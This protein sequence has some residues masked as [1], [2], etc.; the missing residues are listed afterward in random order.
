MLSKGSVN[1]L[2]RTCLALMVVAAAAVSHVSWGNAA[3]ED[4]VSE[5]P[6]GPKT[7]GSAISA[8]DADPRGFHAAAI[9]IRPQHYGRRQLRTLL[10]N[11]RTAEDHALLAAYFRARER[12]FRTKEADQQKLLAE[13]LK[14]NTSKGP[15]RG[16]TIKDSA[17][18]YRD[19]ARKEADLALVHE[20]LAAELGAKK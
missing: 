5:S 9:L 13:Y 2:A 4:S 6:V 1:L 14:G 10:R 15:A 20:R 17:S 12:E 11:A 7:K 3:R 18:Y 19:E 16:D 8:H